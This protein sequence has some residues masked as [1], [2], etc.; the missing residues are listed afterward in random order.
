MSED[1]GATPEPVQLQTSQPQQGQVAINIEVK[2]QGTVLSCAYPIQL[3]LPAEI[4]DQ[5]TEEWIM[6]RPA[7]L[8]KIAQKFI[9]SKQQELALIK[10]I[11]RSKIN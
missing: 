7:L 4:M 2:P 8:Q 10:H 5:M 9:A 1:N 11:N 6:Q 3:G